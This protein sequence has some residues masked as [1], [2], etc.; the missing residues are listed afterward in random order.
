MA[1]SKKIDTSVW[2][3]QTT[4]AEPVLGW[5]WDYPN[6]GRFGVVA[7]PWHGAK[8]NGVGMYTLYRLGV[9]F[10][11]IIAYPATYLSDDALKAATHFVREFVDRVPKIGT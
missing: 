5:V 10:E 2:V 4:L 11:E 3:R 8:H 1:K 9:G 6:V 7:E